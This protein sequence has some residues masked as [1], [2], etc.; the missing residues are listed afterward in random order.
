MVCVEGKD[1]FLQKREVET[2]T[3]FRIIKKIPVFTSV[4]RS[5]AVGMCSMEM[6]DAIFETRNHTHSL[7]QYTIFANNNQINTQ[8]THRKAYCNE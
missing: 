1:V 5:K 2:C 7:K 3:H 6:W 4:T 8:N